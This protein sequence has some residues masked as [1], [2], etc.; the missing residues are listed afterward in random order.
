MSSLRT[1]QQSCKECKLCENMNV[2]PVAIEFSGSPVD[3]LFVIGAHVKQRQDDYQEVLSAPDKKIL[4]LLFQKLKLKFAVTL[5][6]KCK[7]SEAFVGPNTKKEVKDCEHWI[8][9]EIDEL[10]PKLVV[11]VGNV[12]YS[13]VKFDMVIESF[14]KILSS[15][16]RTDILLNDIEAAINDKHI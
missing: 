3:V 4:E 11:G 7:N 8:K 13:S 6:V 12:K 1:R 10:G 15:S 16:P 2:S 14:N 9:T 5:L